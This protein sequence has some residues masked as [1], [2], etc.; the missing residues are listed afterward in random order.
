MQLLKSVHQPCT[1]KPQE[2]VVSALKQLTWQESFLYIKA[3]NTCHSEALLGDPGMRLPIRCF[4]AN[5]LIRANVARI[6]G[7]LPQVTWL[8]V[9]VCSLD[10]FHTGYFSSLGAL[11][12]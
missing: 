11:T 10:P 9:C 6:D 3:A 12:S 2:A 7:S 8:C 4:G 1:S 5:P